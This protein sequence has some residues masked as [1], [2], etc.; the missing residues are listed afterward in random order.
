MT[1]FLFPNDAPIILGMNSYYLDFDQL[2][3]YY[4]KSLGA[5]C[6]FSKNMTSGNIIFFDS[7]SCID[8][9]FYD[10]NGLSVG[11]PPLVELKKNF[12][13]NDF[14]VSVYALPPETIYYWSSLL[15]VEK[16]LDP[17][18]LS[19]EQLANLL[20]DS[21][22]RPGNGYFRI[23][24]GKR[25]EI[26]WVLFMDKRIHGFLF[27]GEKNSWMGPESMPDFLQ[28]F[29]RSHYLRVDARDLISPVV[30]AETIRIFSEWIQIVED[31]L[32]KR[33]ADKIS[34][35]TM[36]KKTCAEWANTYDFLD[37]FLAEVQYQDGYLIFTGK[38]DDYLLFSGLYHVLETIMG[39]QNLAKEFQALLEKWA[40]K[41][42][43]ASKFIKSFYLEKK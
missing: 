42:P 3:E 17:I 24:G 39:K 18:L 10:E 21:K 6:V 4:Q 33:F 28:H 2:F 37:P 25:R 35:S 31:Y 23:Q 8:Y 14:R 29:Q 41:H 13:K 26:G 7:D 22:K 19:L 38:V 15:H 36:F 27:P 12:Q 32:H 11:Y 40:E 34:F 9:A 5:G 43:K 16:Y 20:M 1:E 30:N